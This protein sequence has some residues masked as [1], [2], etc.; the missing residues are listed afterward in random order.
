MVNSRIKRPASLTHISVI[1]DDCSM[2]FWPKRVIH[3][4]VLP[5]SFKVNP[6]APLFLQLGMHLHQ[7][8]PHLKRARDILVPNSID[9][10]HGNLVFGLVTSWDLI[11]YVAL[12]PNQAGTTRLGGGWA[13][14]YKASAEHVKSQF[15]PNSRIGRSICKKC[16]MLYPIV[17]YICVFVSGAIHFYLK[18]MCTDFVMEYVYPQLLLL[19]FVTDIVSTYVHHRHPQPRVANAQTCNS[20]VF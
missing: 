8:D 20:A 11:R 15:T 1:N 14:L 9:R 6:Y 17:P 16:S 19:L 2:P 4:L 13:V 10:T 12:I 18:E 3:D 7:H 5:R